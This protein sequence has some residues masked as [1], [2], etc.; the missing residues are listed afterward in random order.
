MAYR[1]IEP[2]RKHSNRK[3]M[4]SKRSGLHHGLGGWCYRPER[5]M[6]SDIFTISVRKC[7]RCGRL[8][9]SE[10][11]VKTGLGCRCAELANI[12]EQEKAPIDGQIELDEW[13]GGVE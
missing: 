2:G 7:K 10:E 8:L 1:P 4:L 5:R 13:L 3:Q 12:E 9:T 6:M 11:G